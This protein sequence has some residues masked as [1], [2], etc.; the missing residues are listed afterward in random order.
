MGPSRIRRAQDDR[1]GGGNPSE[2]CGVRRGRR[3]IRVRMNA[4]SNIARKITSRPNDALPMPTEC[5]GRIEK[6]PYTNSM[7]TQYTSNDA[8]PN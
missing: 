1:G 8:W 7:C 2:G 5:F 6:R 4:S 3:I